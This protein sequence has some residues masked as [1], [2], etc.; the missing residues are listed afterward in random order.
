[1][2]DYITKPLRHAALA[3]A[4]ARWIPGGAESEESALAADAGERQAAALR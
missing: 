1:M 4:L 3:E 2:D